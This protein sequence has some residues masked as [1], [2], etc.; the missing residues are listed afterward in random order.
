MESH[1]G[2]LDVEQGRCSDSVYQWP[3][4]LAGLGV[5]LSDGSTIGYLQM[6]L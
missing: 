5:E 1:Q 6:T 3:F 2:F 4:E